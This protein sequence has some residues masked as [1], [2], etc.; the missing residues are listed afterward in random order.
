MTQTTLSIRVDE[1]LKKQFCAVCNEFGITATAAV[2]LYAKA[3]VRQ[4]RIPFD[5]AAGEVLPNSEAAPLEAA[6]P[7]PKAPPAKAPK[8]KAPGHKQ[9]QTRGRR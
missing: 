6:K 8:S 7:A 5:I 1:A 2:T 3:V 9:Q 4:R